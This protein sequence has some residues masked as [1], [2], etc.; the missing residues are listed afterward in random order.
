MSYRKT[1]HSVYDLKY[2]IVWITKYRKP[3]LRGE[4]GKRVRELIRQTCASLD[5][6]IV[7]GHVAKDHVHLLVSVPPNLA[8]SE[9]VKRLK[10]R[11]SRLMLEEFGEL[12]KV[13][14]GRH[15]WARGYFVA[16]SGNVTDEIIAEYIEKQAQLAPEEGDQDFSVAEL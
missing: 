3:I 13:Y 10:G 1:A 2:H 11:S 4:I 8:V 15:L 12:R 7:K 14:W 16:S 9:L 5:V 6:Y